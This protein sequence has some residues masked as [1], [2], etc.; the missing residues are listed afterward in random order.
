MLATADGYAGLLPELLDRDFDSASQELGILLWTLDYGPSRDIDPGVRARAREL[1][2][3]L[4]SMLREQRPNLPELEDDDWAL[5]EGGSFSM[6]SQIES[7]EGP[8]HAVEVDSF[9]LL[10][11]QVTNGEYAA[12]FEGEWREAA[13]TK[14]RHPAVAMNWSQAYVFSAWLGGRLPTE[15]E[16]EYAARSGGKDQQ[17]PWG[18]QT[19]DIAERAWVGQGLD[20]SP[21]PVS[22]RPKGNTDQGVSDGAG[23]VWEWVADWYAGYSKHDK[24]NP[25]GPIAG[26]DRVIRGGCF[27]VP[28]V[29]ARASYRTWDHPGIG[30][31]SLGF[32]VV[33]PAPRS[34]EARS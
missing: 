5:L 33:V 27:A 8:V 9:R 24:K 23:N 10:K 17:Y 31:G 28:A 19:D 32:R 3:S 16:W 12:L 30:V 18:D 34:L 2:E 11:H 15:A 14:P 20:D 13:R 4:V 6:G 25:W 1:R 29:R 7:N 26:G 21:L 22:S